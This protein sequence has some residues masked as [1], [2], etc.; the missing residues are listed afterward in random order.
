MNASEPSQ[1]WQSRTVTRT[2]AA[3]NGRLSEIPHA[4]P[5]HTRNLRHSRQALFVYARKSARRYGPG[6]A[7]LTLAPGIRGNLLRHLMSDVWAAQVQRTLAHGLRLA[8]P[9]VCLG[10][11]SS[12]RTTVFGA[13][14]RGSN[15]LS[16]NC[17]NGLTRTKE[18]KYAD[19]SNDTNQKH[20]EFLGTAV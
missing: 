14:Y 19:V 9:S 2:V 15:P 13:D 10:D 6:K 16:P 20:S 3:P 11:S 5:R 17:P 4:D 12:G 1:P 18:R 8:C 7:V